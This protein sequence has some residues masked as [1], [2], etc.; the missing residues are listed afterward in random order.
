MK[1]RWLR[2]TLILVALAFPAP[3]DGQISRQEP[4]FMIEANPRTG[5]WRR[6]PGRPPPPGGTLVSP[7]L[8]GGDDPLPLIQEPI[9]PLPPGMVFAPDDF[10]G[11]DAES[12]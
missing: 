11:I 12:P 3:A 1:R 8:P 2:V 4:Y 9:T 7:G 6:V 10:E 5:E